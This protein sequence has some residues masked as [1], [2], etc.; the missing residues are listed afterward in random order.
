M[1]LRNPYG[2]VRLEPGSV[3]RRRAVDHNDA[4][5]WWGRF[6]GLITAETPLFIGHS[7]AA[8]AAGPK[9]A[10]FREA[11]GEQRYIIPGSTLKGLF[12]SLIE[13]LAPG[14]L[15]IGLTNYRVP[16]EYL[17][18]SDAEKVCPACD[19]FGFVSG[20]S[21][22][23]SRLSF[24]DAVA[25]AVVDH[26]P[27]WLPILSSPKPQHRAW[28]ATQEGFSAGRK[29]YYHQS[30]LLTAP[31]V[32]G[33]PGKPQNAFVQPLGPGTTFSFQ[34]S[35]RDL[36]QVEFETLVFALILEPGLRH[37][38]GQGKPVGLGS[39]R[40]ELTRLERTE[41]A[42]A[43]ASGAGPECLEGPALK[44]T[45][46]N[47][48]ASFASRAAKGALDDLRRIWRWPP[49]Q[50]TYRYPGREWFNRNPIAPMSEF[51]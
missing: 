30:S 50:V 24:D 46:E 13:A 11:G 19:L 31:G 8:Q 47:M 4:Q 12:R 42:P 25:T 39:V 36:S 49:E 5:G 44:T 16:P 28:Y 45:A 43:L 21:L 32:L 6:E 1:T 3:K 14:C 41:L 48:A 9:R 27:V 20:S 7:A 2:F 10:A 33:S 22:R 18:C 51:K 38:V 35:F 34:G 23:A 15:R 29:F 37:K 40:I 26:A 17:A